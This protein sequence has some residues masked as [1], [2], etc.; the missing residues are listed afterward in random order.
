MA[1]ISHEV[2]DEALYFKVSWM[3]GEM[4]EEPLEN[5][6]EP[7]I[8]K[9]EAVVNIKLKAYATAVSLDLAPFI[10]VM[11]AIW[12]GKELTE[13]SESDEYDE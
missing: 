9:K 5:L 7:A 11:V 6:I 3:S 2:E 4:S 10:K 1:V 13:S 12:Q 8:G